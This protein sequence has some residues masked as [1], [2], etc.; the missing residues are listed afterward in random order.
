MTPLYST[1]TSIK[2]MPY[3]KLLI[4]KDTDL[5]AYLLKKGA[6]VNALSLNRL[7]P[8][9]YACG[10]GCEP[11]VEVLLEN[12]AFIDPPSEYLGTPLN[13]ACL[14][15]HPSCVEL[16]LLKGAHTEF[17][18]HR[19]HTPLL[20]ALVNKSLACMEHLLAWGVDTDARD[21]AGATA[22]HFSCR[23]GDDLTFLK[24]L[25][26]HGANV[27]APNHN[28]DNPLHLVLLLAGADTEIT[29]GVGDTPLHN[30]VETLKT[31]VETQCAITQRLL[32]ADVD[33]SVENYLGMTAF[34]VAV[35]AEVKDL[36]GSP[37]TPGEK[38]EDDGFAIEEG[39]GEFSY[40]EKPH[41]DNIS[42][43]MLGWHLTS[44]KGKEIGHS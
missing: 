26:E 44:G 31:S 6:S 33:T 27:N 2:F 8:L 1:V 3:L 7:T 38:D 10:V 30:A 43:R 40:T 41:K 37:A 32:F 42:E 19:G 23:S 15:N 21:F 25:V 5:E 13:A 35:Y 18:N 9:H 34:D 16:L 12:G 14:F 36:L 11:L 24:V 29:N 22:L 28:A 20:T 39:A 17:K 4:G